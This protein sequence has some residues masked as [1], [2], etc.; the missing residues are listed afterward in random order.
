MF[1]AA[2]VRYGRFTSPHLIDRW[3]S[4]N[5]DGQTVQEGLFRTVE[6][7]VKAKN[8]AED[9]NA[10]EFELLTATA[11]N[12]FEREQVQVGVVEVG[13]GGRQD[14]TNVLQNPHVTVI[15]NIGMD[16][17]AFLGDSIEAIAGH[18][19]GIMKQRIPCVFDG[20]NE[21]AVKF[22]VK[23]EAAK[24][25]VPLTPMARA[26]T[27]IRDVMGEF[28]ETHQQRHVAIALEAFRITMD[29][30]GKPFNTMAILKAAAEA[31]YPGRLQILDLEPITGRAQP[32]LVDGAHNAASATVLK[33]YVDHRLRQDDKP[34]TWIV[35]MSK[36]KD[37]LQILQ[38]MTTPGDQ[39][40]ATGYGPVDGMPWVTSAPSE[41][42]ESAA[43]SCDMRVIH[44]LLGGKGGLENS[45][46]AAV[47]RANG[48]PLIIAGSLYLVSDVLRLLRDKGLQKVEA[49]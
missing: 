8:D 39:L 44:E 32:V 26:S 33:S 19:V 49:V 34:V 40:L 1:G 22:I 23:K 10:S 47:N 43:K 9:I 30:I 3:D 2:G 46:I 42:I 36:G 20:S 16:H 25:D 38:N 31:P 24:L 13:M 48:G 21:Q 12:V 27:A 17:Q 15:A 37:M 28:L 29:E 5:I 14:A 7:D 6:H 35:A 45:I 41:E 11:F 18:K 4:I